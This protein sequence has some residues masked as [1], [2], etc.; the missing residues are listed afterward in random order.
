MNTEVSDVIYPESHLNSPLVAGKIVLLLELAE[1]PHNQILNDDTLIKNLN[2]TKAKTTKTAIYKTQQLLRTNILQKFPNFRNYRHI[3]YPEC[4]TFLFAMTESYMTRPLQSLMNLSSLV[5]TKIGGRIIDLYNQTNNKLGLGED[6]LDEDPITQNRKEAILNLP[7]YLEGSRWYKSFLFWFTV[8]TE[9]RNILKNTNRKSTSGAND[10]VIH[11]SDQIFLIMNRNLCCI[12]VKTCK[13]V[14]YLTFEMVLMYS[15]VIEGRLMTDLIMTVDPRFMPLQPRIHNLWKIIDDLFIDLGNST[16]ELVAIIEPFALAMLQ[17]KDASK[18]LRGAFLEFC[19]SE[20]DI[21]LKDSGY[22]S[23][24]NR[25]LFCSA[26]TN[27]FQIDDIHLI[28]EFFS[29]FRSFGHP[30]LEAQ[31]AAKKV[32]E[33]M[34]KP[35]LIKFQTLMKGHAIFCG[36]IINGYRDNHSGVWPPCELPQHSSKQIKLAKSNNE[37]LTPEICANDWKSFVGF[38]FKCFMPLTLDEDLTMYMKD[39][40]LASIKSEWDSCYP[41]YTLNYHAPRSTTSRR[42]IEVFLKDEKFDPYTLIDYVISGKYLNDEEF[43]LSYSLKEKEIKQ[44]GRLFA[45]MT[46]QMRACQ[47]VA[48]SLI[49]TG[50]GKYFRE[51]GMVKDE[52]DLLKTLHK[53]S[54]SSVPKNLKHNSKPEY[55]SNKERNKFMSNHLNQSRNKK[56]NDFYQ[57]KLQEEDVQY[58]TVSSFLTTDLQKFCLNWRAETT[59]IFAERL[60]EIYGLPDRKSVV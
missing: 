39:K 53:L 3:P 15:D 13:R 4:N 20:L 32:R 45:K 57:I 46:Y 52:H 16:Y 12:Y 38:H 47:V 18:L 28:S 35:K 24:N 36:T 8:K 6:F 11:E 43:N 10:L 49:A 25:Y 44:V 5:Y 14:Y 21:F 27:I 34:N 17:L 19:L 51:N 30:V 31:E 9:F 48:E 29:F 7:R 26:L 42:L 23:E 58:E 40:A 55:T 22:L 60:N 33:H 50:V 54:I 1:L 37:A 59:N 2:H 41:D 56:K